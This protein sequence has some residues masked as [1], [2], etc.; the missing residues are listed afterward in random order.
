MFV[1]TITVTFNFTLKNAFAGGRANK[2]KKDC[3]FS[4]FTP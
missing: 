1:K 4:L 2:N 3:H